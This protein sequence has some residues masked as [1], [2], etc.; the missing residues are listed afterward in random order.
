MPRMRAAGSAAIDSL[1][2]WL[3]CCTQERTNVLK[4]KF[5]NVGKREEEGH[6]ARSF[7]QR[8]E[9]YRQEQAGECRVAA[10]L[11][12]QQAGGSCPRLLSVLELRALKGGGVRGP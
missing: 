8:A 2:A 12:S 4:S 1:R 5:D 11:A 10:S 9:E 6:Q 3:T 7:K